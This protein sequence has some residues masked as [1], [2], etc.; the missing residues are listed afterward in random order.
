MTTPAGWYDDGSG[1]QRWWDGARW[2]DHYAPASSPSPD[3]QGFAAS[4]DPEPSGATAPTV[5]LGGDLPP[6]GTYAGGAGADPYAA[7]ASYGSA[8]A[9]PPA[10]SVLGLIGLGLAVL[11]TILSCIPPVLIAGWA[12]LG[13]GFV[14]S[15]V[16]LFLKGRKWPGI[17]GL[18]VSVLGAI[19]A[20][21]VAIVFTLM[22]VHATTESLPSASSSTGDDSSGSGSGSGSQGEASAGRPTVDEL[23]D[24][25]RI[26]IEDSSGDADSYSD[27]Q[28]TC[29]AEAFESSDID[30]A[31]LRTIAEGT[32][33]LTDPA[34][35]GAFL[36]VFADNLVDCALVQ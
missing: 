7:A 27:A 19:L 14:A 21:V 6:Y 13:A 17:T 25:L 20:A 12:L 29:F 5:P 31:T 23:K 22:A 30:D 24:G 10:I 4:G 28:L 36:E 3:G 9:A 35:A 1:R 2:T 32:D 26:V 34:A 33:V 16:S 8:P 11:G 18:I 15:I